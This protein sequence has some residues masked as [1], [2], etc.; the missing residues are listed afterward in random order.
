MNL[1]WVRAKAAQ[2]Q[3]CEFLRQFAGPRSAFTRE[4]EEAQG[5]DSNRVKALSQI[6]DSFV[7]HLSAGLGSG[8]SPQRQGQLD[9]VSDV[10]EQ[11]HALLEDPKQH[12]AAA[13]M[14]IGAALEEFL[15]TWAEAE[16]LSID[17]A[18]PGIDAY[19]K[20]LRR[21]ELITKQDIKDIA[22]WAG[23]RNHAAHG[24]WEQVSDRGRVRLML[25]GV[26]LFMRQRGVN[27]RDDR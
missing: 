27:G 16:G 7:E 8:S 15:R 17:D 23:S 14:L 18:K 12:P 13:A 21:A 24:E 20:V 9:V 22:S 6:L 19:A 1:A 10:L 4:A 26:N 3:V 2:A 5:Y 25:E 11:A